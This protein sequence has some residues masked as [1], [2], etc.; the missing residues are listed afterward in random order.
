[1]APDGQRFLGQVEASILGDNPAQL[2]A[3]LG[4]GQAGPHEDFALA[5][6]LS[7]GHPALPD[8]LAYQAAATLLMRASERDGAAPSAVI[9]K[10]MRSAIEA[11]DGP[12]LLAILRHYRDRLEEILTPEDGH[13]F[14]VAAGCPQMFH[15][16]AA[17][18]SPALLGRLL[19][20]QRAEAFGLLLRK[21]SHEASLEH[22]FRTCPLGDLEALLQAR[23]HDVVCAMGYVAQVGGPPPGSDDARHAAAME[24]VIDIAA[25]VKPAR[26]AES[27]RA[28]A[29]SSAS[30]S[31]SSTGSVGAAPLAA[32]VSPFGAAPPARQTPRSPPSPPAPPTANLLAALEAPVSLGLDGLLRLHK[33][34]LPGR[35]VTAAESAEVDAYT[36]HFRR[37]LKQRFKSK[38][39]P[40]KSLLR[41]MSG[42]REAC[43]AEFRRLR[44]VI[45]LWKGRQMAKLT[46]QARGAFGKFA[47]ALFDGESEPVAVKC[48]ASFSA[49]K[50]WRHRGNRPRR[51]PGRVRRPTPVLQPRRRA[52]ARPQSQ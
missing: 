15:A 48:P 13:L 7:L 25:S 41:D 23:S 11:S 18:I 21:R 36:R 45:V 30:R 19:L 38:K 50:R 1:M 46:C 6:H 49:Q 31:P 32:L 43:D 35:Q 14:R 28:Q 10:L 2:A 42:T 52:V 9:G 20:M 27:R 34:Q 12:Q 33:H 40:I 5:Q 51:R 37:R 24:S 39:I 44:A 47:P 4:G 22:V 16:V 3:M 17:H 29:Q 8:M 26:G